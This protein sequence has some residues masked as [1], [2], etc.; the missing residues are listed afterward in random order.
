[1]DIFSREDLS[2][3]LQDCGFPRVSLYLPTHWR[4]NDNEQDPIRLKN[5]LRRAEENLSAGGGAPAAVPS[6]RPRAT[7]SDTPPWLE[8]AFRLSDDQLF[9][10]RQGDGLA[11]F[12]SPSGL[13][14]WR[15]PLAFEEKVVVNDRFHIRPLLPLFLNDGIFHVLI[16]DQKQSR[17]FRGSRHLFR[18]VDLPSEVAC[19][20][21]ALPYDE[22]ANQLQLRGYPPTPRGRAGGVMAPARGGGVDNRRRKQEIG[23]Y[24]E[25]LNDGVHQRLASEQGPLVLAGVEYL[26]GLYRR[27]NTYTHLWPKGVMK[28]TEGMSSEE[29]HKRAWSTVENHFAG[30]QQTAAERY[31][32]FAGTARAS[33]DIREIAPAAFQRRVEALFLAQEAPEQWGRFN[34]T[35]QTADLSKNRARGDEDLL[36]FAAAHTLMNG[37]AAF[38]VPREQ[39]PD[40]SPAAALFRY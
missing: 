8:P 31:K 4:W 5:L 32:H 22:T 28:N 6:R 39:V 1:M 2:G 23:H 30:A 29:L 3:L 34:T 11:L 17:L 24:F 36:D 12:L 37:G 26:H 10:R 14:L 9:W 7:S 19:M 15:L 40:D 18:E 33:H 20:P 38:V 27:A 13:K 21:N 25:K 35:A 16:L